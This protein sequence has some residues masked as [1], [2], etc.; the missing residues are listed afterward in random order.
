MASS[1]DLFVTA[2]DSLSLH[3][4]EFGSRAN[5]RT[6]VMCL[7]GF[8][9][10]AEDFRTLAEAVARE[11]RRVLALDSR[12]RGRSQFDTDRRTIRSPSNWPISSRF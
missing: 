4:L 10:T 3:V 8:S 12:G 5:G 6:P 7:P 1:R 2:Q 11:D 9:R